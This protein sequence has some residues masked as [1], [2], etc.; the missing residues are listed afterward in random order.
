M[1]K[2]SGSKQTTTV[3]RKNKQE[4][5]DSFIFFPFNHKVSVTIVHNVILRNVGKKN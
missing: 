3:E 2:V 1:E 5:A 4:N